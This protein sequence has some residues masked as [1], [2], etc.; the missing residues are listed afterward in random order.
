MIFRFMIFIASITLSA[1]AFAQS[2]TQISGDVYH[3][4]RSGYNS[5]VYITPEGA[6][7][8]DPLDVITARWLEREINARWGVPVRYVVY[9]HSHADHASG[10]EGF[11]SKPVFVSHQ[12]TLEIFQAEGRTQALPSQT[13]Q[14]ELTLELG[15]KKVQLIH[16]GPNHSDDATVMY[17]PDE[18]VLFGVDFFYNRRL[19][20]RDLPGAHLAGWIKSL[21][22][23]EPLDFDYN[24]PGHGRAGNKDDFIAFRVYMEDL[25]SEAQRCMA[26][27]QSIS[28]IQNCADL[29]KYEGWGG[30]SAYRNS[31]IAG[32]V[33]L[34][35][36][37]T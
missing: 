5:V 22:V 27:H 19:A 7:I 16:P 4:E 21:K 33:R 12:R 32:A 29:S 25:A 23:L 24:I 26:L 20:W 15:G 10:G 9:S 36:A 8:G 35:R 14:K 13:Y 30:Y 1:S 34:L 28:A 31:N 11:K 6:I 37:G 2:L 18:K 17:F 3:V